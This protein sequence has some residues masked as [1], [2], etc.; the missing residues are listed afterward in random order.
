[1]AG[2]R[3]GSRHG[4]KLNP[5][6]S[7][8]S[9]EAGLGSS[10]RLKPLLQ[11]P[12]LPQRRD[13][14]SRARRPSAPSQI[15]FILAVTLFLSGCGITAPRSSEGFADLDSLGVFDTDR[16]LT[17][18]IGPALLRLAAAHMDDD[19]ETRELLRGLDGVRI[20]IYEIDGDA[21]RVAD[22]MQRMGDRLQDDGWERVM[23]VRTQDEQA[24]MLLRI[25]DEQICGMT[26]L[27]SDNESEAVVINLMGEIRPQQF[28]DVMVALDVDAAGVEHVEPLDDQK[29]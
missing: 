13:L 22:R 14:R 21:S 26:V 17:L 3:S 18:S 16:A 25:V 9:R 4:L 24:H 29:G 2:G 15:L 19:P 7:G 10:S 23:L 12:C 6:R 27:V 1:M 8:F 28:S 5:C 20:R 11:T